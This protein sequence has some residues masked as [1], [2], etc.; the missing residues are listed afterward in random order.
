MPRLFT[1]AKE[2][3]GDLLDRFEAGTTSP[4]GYPD[5][6]AFAS[7]VAADAFLKEISRAE[8]IPRE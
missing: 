6:R 4:I 7:V 3:L 5:Y 2:L 8:E 1:D